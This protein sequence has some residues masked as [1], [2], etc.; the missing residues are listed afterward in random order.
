[1]MRLGFGQA[2]VCPGTAAAQWQSDCEARIPR[3]RGHIDLPAKLLRHD[4]M[5][6]LQAKPRTRPLGLRREKGLEDPGQNIRRNPRTMVRDAHPKPA[7]ISAVALRRLC[8]RFD[9]DMALCRRCV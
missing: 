8:P 2:A 7:R 1:M 4:P 9:L 6:N 3:L 5:H